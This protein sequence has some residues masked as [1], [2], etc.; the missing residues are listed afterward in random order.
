MS[1]TSFLRI[2][3]SW[4]GNSISG[5]GFNLNE[6]T[7]EIAMV[8]QCPAADTITHVG[9]ASSS[10]GAGTPPTYAVSIEGV[11]GSGL[12]DGTDKGGGSPTLK[13]FAGVDVT[14][15][16]W[17]ALTN[18][19][20]VAMGE[21]ISTVI[22]YSSGTVDGSNFMR[23]VVRNAVFLSVRPA[24]PYGLLNEA[25]GG[26]VKE[27]TGGGVVIMGFRSATRTYGFPALVV[28]DSNWS[29]TVERGLRFSLPAGWGST[30]KISGIELRG[31]APSAADT[32]AMT[33]YKN[34]A[35]PTFLTQVLIDGDHN[36]APDN[37]EKIIRF[38][39][40]ELQTLNFGDEYIIAFSMSTG[41]GSAN[42][43]LY[44]VD[45]NQ[46]IGALAPSV[47]FQLAN[48]TVNYADILDPGDTTNFTLTD[49]S[50][51]LVQ[52]IIDD[53]TEPAGGSASGVRNPLGGPI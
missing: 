17:I 28:N 23:I 26:W 51:P 43:T 27:A 39:F 44:N 19:L 6:S 50:L 40:D 53:W 37:A 32:V 16:N 10:G 35:S 13:T 34:A 24:L 3:A 5:S 47:S 2:G 11:D 48:R 9:F 45:A 25:G 49:T 7:D 46:D 18:S 8:F 14:Q 12:P 36:A 22:E 29:P 15:M 38:I 33:L 41:G 1:E 52:L 42:L 4:Q 21:F 20:A 31:D 30:F